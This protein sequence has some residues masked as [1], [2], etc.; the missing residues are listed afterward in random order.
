MKVKSM[1]RSGQRGLLSAFALIAAVTGVA[2]T[3][4]AVTGAALAQEPAIQWELDDALRQVDRQ[5]DNFDSAMATAEIV[6][7]DR[8]GNETQRVSGVF[9][10]ND[11]GDIRVNMSDADGQVYLMDRRDL[12]IY[13]PV[14]AIVEE[15]YLPK[16]PQRIAPFMRLGF[17]ETGKDLNDDFLVT[18]I[19]ERFFGNRRTLGLDLTPKSNKVRAQVNRIQLWIDQASWMPVQQVIESTATGEKLTVSYTHMARNLRL[20]PDLFKRKWPRGTRK[21]KM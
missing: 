19:G 11:D 8:D 12:Y 13:D 9:F 14:R 20:N 4:V 3:G 15:Y 21:L 18:A 7:V 2:V 5:A 6:R 1:N 17:S 16:H 10:A